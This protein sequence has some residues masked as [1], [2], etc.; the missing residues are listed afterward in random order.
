MAKCR[1]LRAGFY[2]VQRG[3]GRRWGA[4]EH[5][6]GPCGDDCGRRRPGKSGAS[7]VS[8]SRAVGPAQASA[9]LWTLGALRLH[10]SATATH[11]QIF[12]R[13]RLRA[14]KRSG[15]RWRRRNQTR[16]LRLYSWHATEPNIQR[17]PR[18]RPM[19][20]LKGI[21]P[22]VAAHVSVL[23]GGACGGGGVAQPHALQLL[24]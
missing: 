6:S 15:R 23:L 21:V 17:H 13:A 10:L 4:G 24:L 8:P 18:H 2:F 12:P 22:E 7:R 5:P 16:L 19:H 3:G 11:T 9:Q 14:E 1:R 20:S